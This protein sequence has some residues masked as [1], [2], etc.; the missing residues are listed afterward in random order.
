[1]LTLFL[2]LGLRTI[3]FVLFDLPSTLT[4]AGGPIVIAVV[5]VRV[6]VAAV[7]TI[8]T[9]TTT[10]TVAAIV[11]TAAGIAALLVVVGIAALAL[12]IVLASDIG[13]RACC[14]EG[15]LELLDPQALGCDLGFEV[16]DACLGGDVRLAFLRIRFN[17]TRDWY[18]SLNPARM[19]FGR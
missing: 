18:I 2:L 10:V 13:C 11:T 15:G 17:G 4:T 19:A 9:T 12:S 3:L 1:M 6:I 16:M 7:V 14:G 8:A 5:P